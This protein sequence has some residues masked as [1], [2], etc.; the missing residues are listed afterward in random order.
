MKEIIKES[1]YY[2]LITFNTVYL[3]K[4]VIASADTRPNLQSTR[5]SLL[6]FA[7]VSSHPKISRHL[8]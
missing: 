4:I 8:L 1:V 2:L 6:G 3:E 7:N 5:F